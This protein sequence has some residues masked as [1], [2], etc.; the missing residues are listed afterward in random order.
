MERWG[1]QKSRVCSG[2]NENK[3]FNVMRFKNENGMNK[4]NDEAVV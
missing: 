2:G 1:W 3:V 4:L